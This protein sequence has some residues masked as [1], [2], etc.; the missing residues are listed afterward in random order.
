MLLEGP[1]PSRRTKVVVGGLC[2]AMAMTAASLL[3]LRQGPEPVTED[4]ALD[5]FRRA[6]AEQ[7]GL[8]EAAGATS[9]S[10]ASMT[11]GGGAG[12][13]P[14][15][16]AGAPTAAGAAGATATKTPAGPP[17]LQP[18]T[19]GV[20]A[21]A[22]EGYEYTDALGGSRHDYPSETYAV[23]TAG[24]CGR[25]FSWKPLEE[26]WDETDFCAVGRT[27]EIRRFTNYH[28]FFQRGARNDYTCAPGQRVF[29][30]DA[31]PGQTWTWKCE[32]G[33]GGVATKVT[34]I[35]REQLTVAGKPIETMRLK[36][37]STITGVNRGT[38]V[39]ERWVQP[40]GGV[41][42]RIV[43]DVVA[44]VESPFGPVKYEEHYRI[45]LKSLTPRR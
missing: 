39:Q 24:H 31:T 34:M 44:D 14:P 40:D 10:V 35:G 17:P 5:A 36:Y 3:Y 42:V 12:A 28:E 4:A 33:G 11:A 8:T 7:Q 18:T 23:V 30:A 38:Q 21:Y 13:A 37:E 27:F 41:F 26:R 20:Y 16:G 2:L 9:T 19:E 1:A 6:G 43:T 45:D 25:T 29:I 15:G 22:T 32:G